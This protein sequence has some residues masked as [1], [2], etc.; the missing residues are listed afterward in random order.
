MNNFNICYNALCRAFDK[1]GIIIP[2]TLVKIVKPGGVIYPSLTHTHTNN[3]DT[4][5]DATTNTQ[6]DSA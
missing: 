1:E 6:V 2:S 3:D 5:L 4:E